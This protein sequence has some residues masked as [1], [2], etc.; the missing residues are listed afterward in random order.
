[1][2][3]SKAKL[4]CD[5]V[6]EVPE[7]VRGAME[8]FCDSLAQTTTMKVGNCVSF[9]EEVDEKNNLYRIAFLAGEMPR[10]ELR[11]LL[12]SVIEACQQALYGRP[13]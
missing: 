2:Q 7:S 9:F 1:M 4:N 8:E 12:E 10:E 11:N 13:S 6:S 5:M 3:M